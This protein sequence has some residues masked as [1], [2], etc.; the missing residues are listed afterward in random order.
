MHKKGLTKVNGRACGERRGKVFFALSTRELRHVLGHKR[1]SIAP[2]PRFSSI[3]YRANPVNW[4]LTVMT[5]FAKHAGQSL[6]MLGRYDLDADAIAQLFALVLGPG[7]SIVLSRAIQD[8][9][10]NWILQRWLCRIVK[11]ES[12]VLAL[13][14]PC[15]IYTITFSHTHVW[16]RSQWSLTIYLSADQ[17]QVGC[18]CRKKYS[19]RQIS[20]QKLQEKR[21]NRRRRAWYT[22]TH[23]DILRFLPGIS[24]KTQMKICR[25]GM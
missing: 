11:P 17:S 5:D 20:S 21:L 12:C 9:L 10:G 15:R 14:H 1:I 6:H 24:Q 18:F 2:L 25:E 3:C 8:F 23:Y 19:F 13:R 22:P 16:Y 7:F 4:R